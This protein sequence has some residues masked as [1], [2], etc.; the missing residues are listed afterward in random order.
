MF[1]F[2]LYSDLFFCKVQVPKF[3]PTHIL[4]L[5][6]SEYICCVYS[7]IGSLKP[8]IFLSCRC[9][10]HPDQVQAIYQWPMYSSCAFIMC[11]LCMDFPIGLG[12]RSAIESIV[13]SL[14][15]RV[16]I[17]FWQSSKANGMALVI[18]H[19]G[20]P[21]IYHPSTVSN[22][23]SNSL[24]KYPHDREILKVIA[25]YNSTLLIVFSFCSLFLVGRLSPSLFRGSSPSSPRVPPPSTL[26]SES[27]ASL[28]PLPLM[29]LYQP[30]IKNK[31]A[32][33]VQRLY[34]YTLSRANCNG[35]DSLQ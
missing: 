29:L 7:L 16:D 2:L 31:L 30:G 10:H 27:Q 12:C 4:L 13:L 6:E 28:R 19:S 22:G 32:Q 18:P 5:K 24:R 35:G 9:K 20:I 14:C 23:F 11:L 15:H 3:A 26:G 34:I 17:K 21:K 33:I 8:M 25:W 1:N